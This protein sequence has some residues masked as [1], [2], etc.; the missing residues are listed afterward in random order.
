MILMVLPIVAMATKWS[1]GAK[2]IT[3]TSLDVLMPLEKKKAFMVRSGAQIL[4]MDMQS[5]R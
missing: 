3:I 5:K 4:T 2:I 1:T